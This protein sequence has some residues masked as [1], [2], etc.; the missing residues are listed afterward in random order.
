M[1][2]SLRPCLLLLLAAGAAARLPAQPADV[3]PAP[4]RAAVVALAHQLSEP[5]RPVPLPAQLANPFAP[6]VSTAALPGPADAGARN[7]AVSK[8]PL[9]DA[10]APLVVP[11]GVMMLNGE[12]I[13]LFG[14][15]RI[16]VGDH[17]PITFD[18]EPYVLV[19]SSIQPDSF[20]LRLHG[21]E[22]TRSL[23]PA[24]RP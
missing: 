22:T 12:P 19:I 16:K 8:R 13:L 14:Q 2:M 9:L 11:T 4:R 6:G 17:L 5:P 20:T 21:E 24:N 10:I 1:T 23:K 18:G 3:L 15:K 7:S